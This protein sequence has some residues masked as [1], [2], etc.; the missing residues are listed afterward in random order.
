MLLVSILASFVAFLDGSV[1]NVALPAMAREL[2]GGLLFQ[3][4]VVDAYLVTLG[5]LML[6]AGSL[7]DM[8]GRKR[9]MWLG[10]I[11]FGA[12]SAVCAMAPSGAILI[13]S[14]AIQG[15][16][17]ALLVPSSLAIIIDTFSGAVQARAIGSWTAW[18][19]IAFIIGPVFGG[20]LVDAGSWRYVFAINLLPIAITLW[21]LA[22]VRG[23]GQTDKTTRLDI[24]G[25]GLC[26]F[27]LGAFVFG[28]ISQPQYGWRHEIVYIPLIVGLVAL[29]GFVWHEWRSP[30]PMLPLGLFRVRNF[31]AGNLATV[32]IYAGL[33]LATFVIT[34]FVQQAG[35]YSATQAGMA[36]M[37][38]TIMMFLLSSRFGSLAGRFGP[39]LFMAAGPII[40]ACGFVTML[41]VGAEVSYWS[42]LPGVVLF[43]L[44][45]SV[46][47]APLTS[48]VLGSIDKH[49]AGIGSAVNNAV[50][51]IA[52]LVAIAVV[53]SIVGN[54]LDLNGFYRAV[55]V[56][57]CLLFAGGI[58]SAIG[59]Q[60][61]T[62]ER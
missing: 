9:I 23:Y 32:T 47:V 37:P 28:L 27:G 61:P 19:G 60:N 45:L 39:R 18:T 7:S 62:A 12:A 11:G 13:A 21:L 40:A 51:R 31:A 10:L 17:G 16:A 57:A 30:R 43:G 14:R 46:T 35:G 5:A 41:R 44:G 52:G 49:Q 58:I 26:A 56:V 4:W 2:H 54:D 15:I 34:I 53:G 8:F 38:V 50:A 25:A 36:L 6:I 29:A 1:I 33:S 22:R 20:L 59:I 55:I 3:Q 48:A 24:L 42:L